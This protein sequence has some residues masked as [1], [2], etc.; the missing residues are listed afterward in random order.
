MVI[1]GTGDKGVE[2]KM[3][4]MLLGSGKTL[5]AVGTGQPVETLLD[6]G[7]AKAAYVGL[8]E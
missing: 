8:M 6:K 3:G 4:G 1:R 2:G 5:L 7:T